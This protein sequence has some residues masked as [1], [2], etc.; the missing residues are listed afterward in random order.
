MGPSVLW[1]P[2]MVA[3][4][5]LCPATLQVSKKYLHK[6]GWGGPPA[7]Q[8]VDTVFSYVIVPFYPFTWA[9]VVVLVVVLAVVAWLSWLGCRI[10]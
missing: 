8:Q 2:S 3:A 7:L 9:L 10:R 4:L 5:T 1:V 6:K